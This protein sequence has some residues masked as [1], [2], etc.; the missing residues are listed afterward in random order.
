MVNCF[1]TMA[2][3]IAPWHSLVDSLRMK[4]KRCQK[5]D[6]TLRHRYLKWGQ[7]LNLQVLN[8]SI[9]NGDKHSISVL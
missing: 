7:A 5:E 6:V 3:L 2:Y 9:V 8:H 1:L 4:K